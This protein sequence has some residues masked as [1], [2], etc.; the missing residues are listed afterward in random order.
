MNSGGFGSSPPRGRK[1]PHLRTDLQRFD[2]AGVPGA[3]RHPGEVDVVLKASLLFIDSFPHDWM[4]SELM[5][6]RHWSAG[7][8]QAEWPGLCP[9]PCEEPRQAGVKIAPCV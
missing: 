6:F 3:Y 9:R 8:Y 1:E 5:V 7:F 4:R 2:P